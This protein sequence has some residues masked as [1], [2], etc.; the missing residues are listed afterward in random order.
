VK[1]FGWDL[2]KPETLKGVN[3]H[4]STVFEPKFDE[5]KRAKKWAGW[6]RA[7]ERSKGWDESSDDE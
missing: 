1:L 5:K 6:Q 4:G 3:D 7:V 2:S